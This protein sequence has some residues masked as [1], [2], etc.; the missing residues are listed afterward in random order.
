MRPEPTSVE[1][2]Q[3][4]VP[5]APRPTTTV[6]VKEVESPGPELAERSPEVGA[7]GR[8]L[9]ANRYAVAL[10]SQPARGSQ[11]PAPTMSEPAASPAS[12]QLT[13]VPELAAG[14][15]A[16][17]QDASPMADEGLADGA[18]PLPGDSNAPAVAEG[19]ATTPDWQ[20]DFV[21]Q[22]V[23]RRNF[24]APPAVALQSFQLEQRGRVLRVLD[25]DGSVYEGRFML[26]VSNL[27]FSLPQMS[28]AGGVVPANSL[29]FEVMGT[30][31]S[32]RRSLVFQGVI[33][34]GATERI[35]GQAVIGGRDRIVIDAVAK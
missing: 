28:L 9:P 13:R 3:G 31:R 32:S 24:N 8:S 11:M 34:T 33:V 23:M 7:A 16:Q 26:D 6:S 22:Q 25:E 29:S 10:D 4:P 30:N 15:A 35:Q 17:V 21:Q 27:T 12:L 2:P 1:T 20:A 18:E 14:D 5:A 19:E